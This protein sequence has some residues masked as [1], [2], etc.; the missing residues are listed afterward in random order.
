MCTLWCDIISVSMELRLVIPT[1]TPFKFVATKLM[2][3]F[4]D[5]NYVKMQSIIKHKFY[6]LHF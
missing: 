6:L 1:L 5:L 2:P 3:R 4:R